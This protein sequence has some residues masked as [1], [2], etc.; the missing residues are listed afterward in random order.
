MENQPGLVT[1][2]PAITLSAE[3]RADLLKIYTD[4]CEVDPSFMMLRWD[5]SP[6]AQFTTNPNPPPMEDSDSAW[7]GISKVLEAEGLLNIPLGPDSDYIDCSHIHPLFRFENYSPDF[8]N[9]LNRQAWENMAPAHA[10]ATKWLTAPCLQPF[11][12]R[13]A[14]GTRHT[15]EDGLHTLAPS[16]IENNPHAAQA[17]LEAM[18]L[19]LSRKLTILFCPE[20][21]AGGEVEGFFAPSNVVAI[22]AMDD[23][24]DSPNALVSTNAVSVAS[25]HANALWESDYFDGHL[26]LSSVFLYHLLSPRSTTNNDP[27]S[28]MRLHFSIA[29]TLCHE[30]AHG[31]WQYRGFGQPE[32][33][34]F[35]IDLSNEAGYSWIYHVLG[36]EMIGSSPNLEDRFDH[37]SSVDGRNF[38]KYPSLTT[39]VPLRYINAWF[40]RDTWDRI[41]EVVQNKML[42]FPSPTSISGPRYW[43]A[44]RYAEGPKG[45]TFYEILYKDDK[46]LYPPWAIGNITTPPQGVDI[47]DW[48]LELSHREKEIARGNGFPVDFYETLALKG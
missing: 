4:A 16:P 12:Y 14:F 28:K 35:P 27:S 44:E 11:W 39:I 45:K 5:L 9:N 24:E 19:D 20:N 29:T 37:I 38:N 42:F 1:H 21:V 43:I 7:L 22:S 46:I 40:R 17:A 32:S 6:R 33:F 15:Q 18:F 26:A 3:D 41:E 2:L 13:M 8:T 34:I 10:L 23:M 25:R 31:I 48:F 30:L 47:H 36:A